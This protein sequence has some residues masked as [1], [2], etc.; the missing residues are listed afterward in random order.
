MCLDDICMY[1]II[2]LMG[3]LEK[4]INKFS[5]LYKFHKIEFILLRRLCSM[6]H[7]SFANAVLKTSIQMIYFKIYFIWNTDSEI[8][9]GCLKTQNHPMNYYQ[10]LKIVWIL[11]SKF[12]MQF[13]SSNELF[14]EY[15][16]TSIN[17]IF[18]AL[19]LLTL[20]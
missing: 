20:R 3:F 2:I 6:L 19:F 11:N 17:L 18:L 4:T 9:I 13:F 10:V 14:K 16:Q 5:C 12:M 15:W 1:I 7:R 8:S